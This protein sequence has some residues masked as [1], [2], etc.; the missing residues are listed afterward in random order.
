DNGSSPPID[1]I[2]SE[3]SHAKLVIEPKRGSYAARN[4]GIA[5]A[6]GDIFAFTDSDCIPE[7]D[8]LEKG[9]TH[10]QNCPECG[11]VGGQVK[12]FPKTKNPTGVELFEMLYAFDV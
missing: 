4:K 6:K 2:V 11:L 1:E 7:F 5:T 9:V 8:W 10:L 12:V 3:F